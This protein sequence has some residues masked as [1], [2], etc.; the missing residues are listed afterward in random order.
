MK[1]DRW[2]KLPEM[3]TEP[4]TDAGIFT[5]VDIEF[6]LARFNQ[7]YGDYSDNHGKMEIFSFIELR[8]RIM[9]AD[10]DHE[11][12]SRYGLVC[13]I[14]YGQEL[15]KVYERLDSDKE[16]P[17]DEKKYDI[18]WLL[19][20][21]AIREVLWMM[22]IPEHQEKVGQL[23]GHWKERFEKMLKPRQETMPR[24]DGWNVAQVLSAG[25]QEIF[26]ILNGD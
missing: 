2:E 14:L 22:L 18:F 15:S 17:A 3:I 21:M 9:R 8:I 4:E 19:S 23:F 25:E 24:N 20:R 7:E 5:G 10:G 12:A 6:I 26:R 16:M 1:I 13:L 11:N